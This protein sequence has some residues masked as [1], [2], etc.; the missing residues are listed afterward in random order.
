MDVQ[1]ELGKEPEPKECPGG[2]FECVNLQANP[3][4]C[5]IEYEW[6]P[7]PDPETAKKCRCC[8]SCRRACAYNI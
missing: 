1:R 3:K 5:A 6:S 4:I 2:R 8:A 7:A